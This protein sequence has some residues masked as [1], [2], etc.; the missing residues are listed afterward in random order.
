MTEKGQSRFDSAPFL[1]WPVRFLLVSQRDDRIEA[2]RAP[3]GP[4][5]EQDADDGGEDERGDDCER[6]DDRVPLEEGAHRRR[7]S[8]ADEGADEATEQAEHHGLDEELQQDVPPRRTERFPDTDLA[9][10]LR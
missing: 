8:T 4:D 6:R 5:A 10:P 7:A 3:R 1:L 2:G 9:R